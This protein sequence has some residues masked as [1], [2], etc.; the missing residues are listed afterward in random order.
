FLGFWTAFDAA[1]DL[2]FFCMP[3]GGM[4]SSARLRF[5]LDNRATVIFCTPTYALRLA[6][7][8]A[9]EGID[10]RQSEVRIIMVAGEPGGSIPATR[11]RIETT[12]G[13]RVF[14]HYGMTEIGP[15]GIECEDNPAGLH[16]LES[17]C[18]VEVIESDAPS[19]PTPPPRSGGEGRKMGE[20][21]IT[22]LGR[23]GSPVLRYRTGD[24]VRIDPKPCP[25]GRQLVRLEGGILGRADDMIHLRGNNVYPS[26]LE[27]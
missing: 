25:C 9:A 24:L 26:A 16:L 19:S 14:D 2:G 20:L 15:L 3:S 6:E 8:A 13:A 22:N 18:I 17:E 27:A 12:W 7:V 21:V 4:S 1:A 11:Q 10:L 5:L 23:W